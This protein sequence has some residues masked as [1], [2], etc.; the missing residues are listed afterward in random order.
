[1][2]EV[3][4]KIDTYPIE[5]PLHHNFTTS[6]ASQNTGKMVILEVKSGDF[7]GFGEINPRPHITGENVGSALVAVHKFL[8]PAIIGK[9]IF[10]LVGIHHSMSAIEDNSA[11]K[12]A[13]DT[14]VFDLL[15]KM[16]GLPVYALLGGI[17]RKQVVLN[18]WCGIEGDI[19]SVLSIISDKLQY[20]KGRTA[21]VKVGIND[22]RDLD[23]I[24]RLG[25]I[26]PEGTDLIVDAN[27]AWTF[28]R[29]KK[30]LNSLSGT[31]V[32]I[33]EQPVRRGDFESLKKL[34]SSSPI[35]IMA[36]ESLWTQEDA[37]KLIQSNAVDMFNIKPI[38][39]G[40]LFPALR[41]ASLAESAGIRCMIGSTIQT[42]ISAAAQ[43]HFAA[44]VQVVDYADIVI[45]SEFLVEDVASGIDFTK[46]AV[47]LPTKP[48]LGLEINVDV[49]EKY[50]FT[51]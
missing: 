5:I 25:E 35:S 48:G 19:D 36:D 26:L 12:C 39:C 45:P 2:K 51:P 11:A 46:G 10:D 38:K 15:G 18:A 4:E 34:S 41:I 16:V 32:T 3:I 42:S 8:G 1:M 50:Y 14:A 40:G 44:A 17:A 47:D 6:K 24:F 7:S 20:G 22:K 29:A 31:R 49:L 30:I 21:K 33:V 27:Q 43:T 9:N 23:L 13:L 28:T 37:F